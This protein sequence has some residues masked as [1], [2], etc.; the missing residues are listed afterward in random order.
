MSLSG[1]SADETANEAL[2]DKTVLQH[3]E[4]AWLKTD[5]AALSR[6][7]WRRLGL[8]ERRLPT[9]QKLLALAES[10]SLISNSDRLALYQA[11][12]AILPL[13]GDP[14]DALARLLINADPVPLEWAD[15][16]TETLAQVPLGAPIATSVL[17]ALRQTLAHV[18]QLPA[19]PVDRRRAYTL[20]A[21]LPSLGYRTAWAADLAAALAPPRPGQDRKKLD[22]AGKHNRPRPKF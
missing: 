3:L 9:Q 6:A 7:D 2:Q 16:L 12:H 1:L 19:S 18:V 15:V 21:Q 13:H 8:G 20:A 14:L 5:V 22:N 4:L 11:A 10:D 17:A